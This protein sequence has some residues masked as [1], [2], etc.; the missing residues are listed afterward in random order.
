LKIRQK[1]KRAQ[2]A[3]RGKRSR[4]RNHGPWCLSQKNLEDGREEHQTQ[5]NATKRGRRVA[6][7]YRT[8][9]ETIVNGRTGI[10]PYGREEGGFIEFPYGGSRGNQA[11]IINP[12]QTPKR[13]RIGK[14]SR[15]TLPLSLLRI[16][17]PQTLV[18]RKK[19]K[20][21]CKSHATDSVG[22]KMNFIPGA[23]GGFQGGDD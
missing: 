7:E 14:I 10:P 8:P 17:R 19:K 9:D 13:R 15:R 6:P 20:L 3:T 16:R 18:D 5:P 11:S 21:Q 12:S 1:K 23:D 22:K 2:K 4:A